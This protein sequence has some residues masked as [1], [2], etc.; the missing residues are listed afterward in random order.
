MLFIS[1]K[2]YMTIINPL[3]DI[4]GEQERERDKTRPFETRSIDSTGVKIEHSH[5]VDNRHL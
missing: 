5:A 2:Q 4:G 1:S 3:R